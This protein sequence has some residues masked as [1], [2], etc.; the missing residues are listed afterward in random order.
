MK[1][2]SI[3]KSLNK[4]TKQLSI[5]VGVFLVL[6][7]VISCDKPTGSNGITGNPGNDDSSAVD[8]LPYAETVKLSYKNS[9]Q[10]TVTADALYDELS[11][12]EGPIDFIVTG[13]LTDEEFEKVV[14]LADSYRGGKQWWAPYL[15]LDLTQTTGITS[16]PDCIY[17]AKSLG[18]PYSIQTL[19]DYDLGTNTYIYWPSDF[20]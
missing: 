15:G 11:K 7:L 9:I 5:W 3:K 6:L 8:P 17:F 19:D 14:K 12:I 20:N 10:K 16:I 1:T 13:N 18:L 2:I 4:I